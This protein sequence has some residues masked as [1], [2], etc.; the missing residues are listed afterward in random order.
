M[1]RLDVR[2]DLD[3]VPVLP[4]ELVPVQRLR[5]LRQRHRLEQVERDVRHVDEVPLDDRLRL[6]RPEPVRAVLPRELVPHKIRGQWT[7]FFENRFSLGNS[8]CRDNLF[9]S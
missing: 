7:L 8:F 1:Q 4:E 2:D 9:I 5:D 6:Q 3:D